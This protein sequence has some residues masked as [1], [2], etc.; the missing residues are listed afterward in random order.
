MLGR[1]IGRWRLSS[2]ARWADVSPIA[3]LA[4]RILRRSGLRLGRGLADAQIAE[5]QAAYGFTFNRDH[6][7]VLRQV[8]PEGWVDWF[9]D[10]EEAVRDS[11][12]WPIE[13]LLLDV[14]RGFWMPSWGERPATKLTGSAASSSGD[15]G[16]GAAAVSRLLASAAG[17]HLRAGD[18]RSDLL[19]L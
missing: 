11:L 16:Q 2:S 13:G 12:A 8:T 15:R 17:R 9:R 18:C 14:E 19:L 1:E 3:D 10:D 5:I 7:D 4:I 6:A